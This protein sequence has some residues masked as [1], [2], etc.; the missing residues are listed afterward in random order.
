M[1]LSKATT[2]SSDPMT[3]SLKPLSGKAFE[4]KF[5]QYMIVHHQAADQMAQLI[6]THTA[7]PQLQTLAQD[8]IRTQSSEITEM[9][10]WLKQRYGAQPIS[11]PTS[12]PGMTAMMYNMEHLKTLYGITFDEQFLPLMI[13]HHQQ[14]GNMSN[15]LPSKT[16]C[17]ELLT[18]GQNIIKTQGAEIQQMQTWQKEWFDP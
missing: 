11:N 2:T 10:I 14:A 18:L 12:V 4:I 7:H 5:L 3:D 17:P 6:S 1:S 15:L 9:T 8:I 16:Q 13:Q